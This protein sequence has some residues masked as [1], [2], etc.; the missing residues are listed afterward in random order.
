ME[1]IIGLLFILLPVIFKLIGKRLEQSGKTVSAEKMREIAEKFGEDDNTFP[2]WL[3][4]GDL[5]EESAPITVPEVKIPA[6]EVKAPAPVM[7]E[8]NFVEAPKMV[9]RKKRTP[10][11]NEEVAERKR[12]KI[13]PKKLVV[14]SEIMNP[15]YKD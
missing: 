9:Q 8:V 10:I 1:T 12:E 13:D 11:L 2:D 14:Y 4:E 3:N 7:H 15:K 5:H 6:P